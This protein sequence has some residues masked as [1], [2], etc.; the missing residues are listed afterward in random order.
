MVIRQDVHAPVDRQSLHSHCSTAGCTDSMSLKS[1]MRQASVPL[2]AYRVTTFL[3]KSRHW[4][5]QIIF[6][7]VSLQLAGSAQPQFF[8]TTSS[9]L[10]APSSCQASMRPFY[11]T[12]P[13]DCK[14]WPGASFCA[15]RRSD[16]ATASLAW[17]GIT[18]IWG[19][20]YLAIFIKIFSCSLAEK[21]YFRSSLDSRGITNSP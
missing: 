14:N 3:A 11:H 21:I 10:Q 5:G 16:T 13:T 17:R 15:R 9:R 20:L 4:V 6:V 19:S 18:R 7:N 8:S 1:N 2:A 12:S